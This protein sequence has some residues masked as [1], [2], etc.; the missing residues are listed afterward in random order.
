MLQNCVDNKVFI[1][2][3][4]ETVPS[5]I[6]TYP[7]MSSSNCQ[8]PGQHPK[9]SFCYS[10][11]IIILEITLTFFSLSSC[12]FS[13]AGITLTTDCLEDSLLTCYWGCS[14]QKLYE[15]LQKHIYCFQIST[16]QALED[17]L[18]SE[19]LY[20]EQYLYPF[21]FHPLAHENRRR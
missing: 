19:Y 9:R 8:Q 20:Q 21:I 18:Y 7:L 4:L 14:V 6:S 11:C 17:A 2:P 3:V 16:P 10:L 13:T 12:L 1:A 5:F 15:A